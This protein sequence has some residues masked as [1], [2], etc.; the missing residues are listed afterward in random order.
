MKHLISIGCNVNLIDGH[1]TVFHAIR[2]VYRELR[3]YLVSIGNDINYK[4]ESS[5]S[6]LHI[7]AMYNNVDIIQFL[8]E[9]GLDINVCFDGK[10]TPLEF[11]VAHHS[12]EAVEFLIKRG[13]KLNTI[14]EDAAQ[15]GVEIQD[16]L[17][18][19]GV[20]SD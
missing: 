13:A 15:L 8:L 16:I 7:A 12:V 6:L 5:L 2:N 18:R 1:N 9:Q 17:K 11:A 3:E 10:F 14:L 19:V 20:C 4:L